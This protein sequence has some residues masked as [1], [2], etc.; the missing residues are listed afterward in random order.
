M[1]GAI[2]H[3]S[4]HRFSPG[5]VHVSF[6]AGGD[7]SGFRLPISALSL[8]RLRIEPH[9]LTC[10]FLTPFFCNDVTFRTPFGDSTEHTTP[11]EGRVVDH[12][13]NN[14]FYTPAVYG[15][16][17]RRCSPIHYR[18]AMLSG[19]Y[20]SRSTSESATSPVPF[21]LFF[22]KRLLFSPPLLDASPVNVDF[23]P[24]RRRDSAC[25]AF[26]KFPGLG[27]RDRKSVV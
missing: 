12:R 21:W 17:H 18:Q 22:E 9:I 6:S 26:R 8:C 13:W 24:L 15:V 2:L 19:N 3:F 25:V 5:C 20:Q 14:L 1:A 11:Q 23:V 10:T 16:P 4:G 7:L 27:R